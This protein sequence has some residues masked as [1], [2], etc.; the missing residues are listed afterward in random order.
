M[1]RV[2]TIYFQH[3]GK[4]Y[5]ALIS[6]NGKDDTSINVIA[7]RDSIEIHLPAGRL[8]FSIADVLQRLF[9]SSEKSR[10][11]QVLY[12]TENISFQLLAEK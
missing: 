6:V 9:V 11:N 5:S 8:I 1:A 4:S 10:S 2:F 12:I 3:K 7:N